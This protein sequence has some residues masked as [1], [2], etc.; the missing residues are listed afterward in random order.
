M[1]T[2]VFLAILLTAVVC[3]TYKITDCQCNTPDDTNYYCGYNTE[4]LIGPC[5]EGVVYRCVTGG[6]IPIEMTADMISDTCMKKCVAD[7]DTDMTYKTAPLSGC[8]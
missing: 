8:I 6:F 3:S 2:V 7:K 5:N 1:K 4:G